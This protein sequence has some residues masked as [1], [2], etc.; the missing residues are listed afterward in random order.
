VIDSPTLRAESAI[1]ANRAA[2]TPRR[3]LTLCDVHWPDSMAI[4]L[5]EVSRDCAVVRLLC[6]AEMAC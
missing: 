1:G 2:L 3:M 6:V 5:F 4:W